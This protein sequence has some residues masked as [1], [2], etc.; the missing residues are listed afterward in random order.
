MARLKKLNRSGD[1]EDRNVGFDYWLDAARK[2]FIE[3]G[4]AN[5]K[6]DRLARNLAVT[7]G[8]FYWHF[9]NREDLLNALIDDWEKRNTQPLVDAADLDGPPGGDRKFVA[10]SRVWI[11]ERCFSAAYDAAVRDWARTSTKVARI[12]R[13]VDARR[14]ELLEHIFAE[15]GFSAQDAAP[16]ARIMYYHQV[17]YYA[18]GV[19]ESRQARLANVPIYFKA[20]TGRDLKEP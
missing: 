5:V 8:G 4:V 10:I 9:K 2:A 11:E 7:R 1:T 12:V 13:R 3:G 14:I 20:L 18:M 6:V 16:R 17:G 15:L 19:K